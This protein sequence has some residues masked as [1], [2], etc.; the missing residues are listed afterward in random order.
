MDA[1]E[2]IYKYV[3]LDRS[4][5]GEGGGIDWN[6][7]PVDVYSFFSWSGCTSISISGLEIP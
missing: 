6:K 2:A 5:D 7:F 3:F 1:V 4:Q